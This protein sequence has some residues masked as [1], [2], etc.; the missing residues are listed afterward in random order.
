VQGHDITNIILLGLLVI[1]TIAGLMK[2]FV[3]QAIELVGL[4]GSFFIAVLFAGWLAS[5]LQEHTSVPYSPALVIACVALFVGGMIG[6]HFI[7]I[8]A[9]KLVHMSFLGWVD[10]FCGAAVGLIIAMLLGSILITV[11]LELPVSD[12]I[13][14]T[15]EASH[16][17]MFLRPMAPWLFDVVFAHGDGSIEYEK[18]FK[19]GGAI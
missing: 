13:R 16:V 11:T 3:R 18:I 1:G 15:V 14:S 6:F 17:G 10:R 5:I 8:S 12:D 4:I 2:G 19:R 9:R 7:A